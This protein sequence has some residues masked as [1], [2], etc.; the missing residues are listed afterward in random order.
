VT[1]LVTTMAIAA[2]VLLTGCQ[3]AARESA[4]ARSAHPVPAV[5]VPADLAFAESDGGP[6]APVPSDSPSAEAKGTDC[7]ALQDAWNETNQAL[8][9]LSAEHPRA[10]VNSFRAAAKAMSG[11]PAPEPVAKDWATMSDYLDRVNGAFD[12]VDSDD[13]A[14]VSAAMTHTVSAV[15]TDR[16]TAA[17]KRVTA[18]I[19]AGC[20]A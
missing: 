19:A 11:V 13:A 12:D 9:N 16:A 15:D 3:P 4:V 7:T 20:K 14:A 5:S 17:A 10:L 2:A 8:V 6:L 18:F 1:S